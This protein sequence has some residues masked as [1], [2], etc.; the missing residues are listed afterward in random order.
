MDVAGKWQSSSFVHLFTPIVSCSSQTKPELVGIPVLACSKQLVK[1]VLPWLF[2]LEWSPSAR[3]ISAILSCSNHTNYGFAGHWELMSGQLPMLS[4]A[5]GA[6][7]NDNLPCLIFQNAIWG[8]LGSAGLHVRRH[9]LTLDSSPAPRWFL[10]SRCLQHK[11]CQAE[12]AVEEKLHFKIFPQVWRSK[13]FWK[14]LWW[15]SKTF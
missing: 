8:L 3:L 5:L 6:A 14:E 15:F 1:L 12:K 9:I 2:V 4:A 10:G 7:E 11:L 13:V